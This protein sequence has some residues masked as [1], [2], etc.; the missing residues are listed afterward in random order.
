MTIPKSLRAPCKA[1]AQHLTGSRRLPPTRTSPIPQ[2]VTRNTPLSPTLL[3]IDNVGSFSGSDL[4]ALFQ[5]AQTIP[6]REFARALRVEMRARALTRVVHAT[7]TQTA[8]PPPTAATETSPLRRGI[9]NAMSLLRDA[10]REMTRLFGEAGA[11]GGGEGG[12]ALQTADAEAAAE[13]AE[14]GAAAEA[15]ITRT[16]MRAISEADFDAALRNVRPTGEWCAS[17]SF[18]FFSGRWSFFRRVRR[19]ELSRR[20]L[21]ARRQRSASGAS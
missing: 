4:D 3:G 1:P 10:N 20:G 8:S 12:P 7:S 21:S 18:L 5:A 15:S 14:G 11:A 6:A 2:H 16:Q 13:A 9:D 17:A 19:S